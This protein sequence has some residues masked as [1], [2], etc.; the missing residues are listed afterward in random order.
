MDRTVTSGKSMLF[1]IS[2]CR[3]LETMYSAIPQMAQSTNL[4]S[5]G[6]CV[7]KLKRQVGVV[8]TR[9]GRL[10]KA[11]IKMVAMR[12]EIFWETISFRTQEVSLAI[13]KFPSPRS[14]IRSIFDDM[15]F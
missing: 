10:V 8:L 3:S 2:K 11:S 7:I 1:R 13:R 4:L 14:R 12:L 9:F 5:S 15:D 6:S